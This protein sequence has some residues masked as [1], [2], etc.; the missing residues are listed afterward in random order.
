MYSCIKQRSKDQCAN[1]HSCGANN[2]AAALHSAEVITKAWFGVDTGMDKEESGEFR[3]LK[4]KQTIA[5]GRKEPGGGRQRRE[6]LSR[7]P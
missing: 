3:F 6:I 2:T 5:R 7:G 1:T 4:K